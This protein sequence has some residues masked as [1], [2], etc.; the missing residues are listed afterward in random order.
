MT[1]GTLAGLLIRDLIVGREN[2]YARLYDPARKTVRAA[3]TY[4]EENANFVGH[5]VR[6]W[7]RG[8]E[9]KDAAEIP[10]EQ[11]AI[12]RHGLAPVAAYRDA[13][14]VLHE[15][16]AVCTH[17]GCVVRGAQWPRACGTGARERRRAIAASQGLTP[18]R[19]ALLAGRTTSVQCPVP[20]WQRL[21]RIVLVHG[22]QAP[23]AATAHEHHGAARAFA[24]PAVEF[25]GREAIG[26]CGAQ[27]GA[28]RQL[29]AVEHVVEHVAEHEP[30]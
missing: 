29:G 4:L 23:F 26:E 27:V 30:A 14:G 15:V 25:Q 11:A 5:M 16:S 18:P 12:L 7:V 19:P 20:R 22:Q 13:E 9:V 28:G 2:P 17:L 24:L 8:A 21:V 3:G 6:D 10:C 1:H